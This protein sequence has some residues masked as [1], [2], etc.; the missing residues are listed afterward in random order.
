MYTSVQCTITLIFFFFFKSFLK[1][2]AVVCD[3]V[4]VDYGGAMQS[5]RMKGGEGGCTIPLQIHN[6][7]PFCMK[8]SKKA[9]KLENG[10]IIPRIFSST[11][12]GFFL[13]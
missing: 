12:G 7:T 4:K 8:I 13:I 3:G 6:L 2:P 9:A 10:S 1:Y 11:L 5:I